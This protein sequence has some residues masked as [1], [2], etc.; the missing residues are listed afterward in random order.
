[1][2]DRTIA[3]HIRGTIFTRVS[4][5]LGWAVPG[6]RDTAAESTSA[7]TGGSGV[8]GGSVSVRNTYGFQPSLTRVRS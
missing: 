2:S 8:R 7:A 3:L 1:M 5:S 4:W 6:S